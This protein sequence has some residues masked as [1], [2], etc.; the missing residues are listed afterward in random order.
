[1]TK[2]KKTENKNIAKFSKLQLC[3]SESYLEYKDLLIAL[4]DENR[5]YTK[6]EVDDILKGYLNKEVK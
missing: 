4:L 1:M 2:T 3:E 5:E 6:K